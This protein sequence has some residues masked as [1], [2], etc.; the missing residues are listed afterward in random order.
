MIRWKDTVDFSNLS[1]A[2]L[3]ALPRIERRYDSIS[4]ECW[5]TSANDSIHLPN[6]K[7]YTGNALDFRTKNIT[8]INVAG[9][10][11]EAKKQKLLEAIKLDLGPFYFCQLEHL[12]GE[13][14]HLHIQF[15][16][17]KENNELPVV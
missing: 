1:G 6:S 5:V 16:G 7:H 10:T 17:K 11:A 4:T 13:Q 2:M 14:E 15:N 3:M 12:G 8:G 9:L